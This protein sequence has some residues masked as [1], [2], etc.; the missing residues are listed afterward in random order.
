[1]RRV[2]ENNNQGR[3]KRRNKQKQRNIKVTTAL[4]KLRS[5]Q[6]IATQNYHRTQGTIHSATHP[7]NGVSLQSRPGCKISRY[8]I[9]LN[10]WINSFRHEN[11]TQQWTSE[12]DENANASVTVVGPEN[13]TYIH[14]RIYKS[15]YIDTWYWIRDGFI[16]GTWWVYWRD[17]MGLLKGW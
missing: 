10:C 15:T 7:H 3:W 6:P 4:Q 16:E 17:V 1:M 12:L 2:R 8:G 9:E 13:N 14:R 5:Y 11:R